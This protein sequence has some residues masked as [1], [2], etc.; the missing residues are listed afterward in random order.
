[1]LNHHVEMKTKEI[2]YIGNA[3]IGVSWVLDMI[4]LN[5]LTDIT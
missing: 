1:M 4:V 2:P 3:Y 5:K